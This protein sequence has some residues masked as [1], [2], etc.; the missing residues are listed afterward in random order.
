MR[1]EVLSLVLES[2][3]DG[4]SCLDVLLP[5]IDHRNIA[6]TKRNDPSSENVNDIRPLVPVHRSVHHAQAHSTATHIKSIFVNTPIVLNPSGSTSR[7]NFSPS[8][9]AKSVFAAVTAK[10]IHDGFEMNLR[11]ISL[12]CFSISFGWSPTGTFVKPGRSTRV[13]VTTFG[14][15]MRR[16]MGCGEMPA[17]CPSSPRCRARSRRVSCRSRRTSGR[18]GAGTRPTRPRSRPCRRWCRLG[19]LGVGKGG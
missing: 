7:A 15:N 6:K 1:R 16:L 5:A 3:R 11:T 17:F 10:M 18:G 4:L 19:R 2:C 14:E 12:I 8:E 13:S 9:L